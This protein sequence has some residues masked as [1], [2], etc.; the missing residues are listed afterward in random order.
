MT[1]LD[2]RDPLNGRTG[3]D[4]GSGS[5][6]SLRAPF[7]A[8]ISLLESNSFGLTVKGYNAVL[9]ADHNVPRGDDSRQAA[10][11]EGVHLKAL[12]SAKGF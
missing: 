11:G 1:A 6:G 3:R 2:Q 9:I 8:A 12:R 5:R 7:L 10:G 4:E